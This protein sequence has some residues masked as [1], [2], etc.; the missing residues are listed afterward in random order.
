MDTAIFTV[1]GQG[2]IT[3]SRGAEG[4]CCSTCQGCDGWF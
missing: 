4:G 2:A 1:A 3:E